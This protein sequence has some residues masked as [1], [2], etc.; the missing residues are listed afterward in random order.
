MS[1]EVAAVILAAGHGRRYREAC[2]Q[3]LDKLMAVCTGLDGVRRSVFEQ[4]LVNLGQPVA[5]RLVVT[6]PERHG[7]IELA[8]RYGCE[9]ILLASAGMGD[10]LA[11][12]IAASPGQAGWLVL[13][14]DMPWVRPASLQAVLDA[15]QPAYIS[16]ACG[17]QGYGHPV[18]FGS[19]YGAGLLGLS[20]DQGAKRLFCAGQVVPV[21]TDD[22]GIYRDVDLPADVPD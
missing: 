7:V 13:L 17:A 12:A 3:D 16:V 4:V 22:P 11:A 2:E 10:S 18:G 21:P 19:A 14:G 5:R 8:Q 15:M 9:I 6:R 1:R 20:G